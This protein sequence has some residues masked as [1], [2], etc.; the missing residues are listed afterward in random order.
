[1]KKLRNLLFIA[2]LLTIATG[3]AARMMDGPIG[4]F[5]G[6]PLVHGEPVTTPVTNWLF[7]TDV[8][9]IE[10]QLA[11]PPRSRTTWILVSSGRGFI[12]CGIPSFTLWKKWPHEAMLD[13][14]AII[15]IRNQLHRVQLTRVDDADLHATLSRELERKYGAGTSDPE[16][17]WMFRIDPSRT[18]WRFGDET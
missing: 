4:P 5:P 11:E 1:M 12:P 13:G 18:G 8:S 9:E 14:R 15:R 2:L 6:G 7:A 3:L 17:V 16:S 10:M